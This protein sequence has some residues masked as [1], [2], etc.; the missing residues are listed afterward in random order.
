MKNAGLRSWGLFLLLAAALP[1]HAEEKDKPNFENEES[2]IDLSDALRSKQYVHRAILNSLVKDTNRFGVGRFYVSHMMG[3]N[4]VWQ[5]GTTEYSKYSSGLQGLAAGYV[6][7]S[8]HGFELGGELS[9]ITNLFASYKYFLRPK[10]V[11]VWATFGA[12]LGMEL[13]SM[14]FADGPPEAALYSGARQMGFI[15]LGFLIPT[16]DVGFKGE[17]RLNFY[18]FDRIVFTSGLGIIV[19]L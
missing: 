4:Q 3:Y 5:R 19:F 8:G 1:C 16:I 13:K 15:N 2:Y 12:G 7:E 14:S 17:V 10:N 6:A 18:G 11:S 9:A